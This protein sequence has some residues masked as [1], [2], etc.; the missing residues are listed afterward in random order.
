MDFVWI[1]IDI[2]NDTICIKDKIQKRYCVFN[3]LLYYVYLFMLCFKILSIS[4]LSIS[5]I[6]EYVWV[7]SMEFE[8]SSSYT[9]YKG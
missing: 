6:Q 1:Y 4:N 9:P 7:T 2:I 8:S 3:F 5:N